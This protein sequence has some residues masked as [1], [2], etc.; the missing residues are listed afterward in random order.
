[1]TT[2]LLGTSNGNV[3]MYDIPKAFENERFL[4]KKRLD[5]GIEVNLVKTFLVK[6]NEDE[7]I[8]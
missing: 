7:I 5:N 1:M 3:Y 4:A 8:D 6:A 2:A